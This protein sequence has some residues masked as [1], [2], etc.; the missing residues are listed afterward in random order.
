MTDLSKGSVHKELNMRDK[1]I[2]LVSE[3]AGVHKDKITD[4][5]RL[6][7]ELGLDSL[8]YVELVMAVEEDFDIDIPDH[9]AELWQTVEDLVKYVEGYRR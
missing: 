2:L 9:H 1:V 3:Q 6:F 8:D 5:A 7:E 4:G